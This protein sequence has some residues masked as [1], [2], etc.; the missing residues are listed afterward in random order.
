ME[1][2]GGRLHFRKGVALRMQYDKSGNLIDFQKSVREWEKA[3]E[4]NPSQYIWRRRIQQYGPQS[5][6]PYPFYDW[7]DEAQKTITKRGETPIKL[8]VNLTSSERASPK[9]KWVQT[10]LEK[11]PDPKNKLTVDADDFEILPV[12]IAATGHK[13]NTY[14]VHIVMRPKGTFS[15]NNE[16]AEMKVWLGENSGHVKGFTLP[17]NTK[18]ATSVEHRSA[19]FEWI[20]SSKDSVKGYVVFHVCSKNDGICTVLRK[21]FQLTLP[22]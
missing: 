5:D 20:A 15:W 9:K 16:G 4:I 18:S 12:V 6:K 1:D 22:Q 2:Q 3:L 7:V 14:R 17:N 11:E 19:E 21:D 8:R 10:L 13:K